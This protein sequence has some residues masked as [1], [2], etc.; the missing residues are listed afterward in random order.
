MLETEAVAQGSG[1]P[2]LA[3]KVGKD[4]VSVAD[5]QQV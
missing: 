3:L 2:G 4:V 1:I 5:A